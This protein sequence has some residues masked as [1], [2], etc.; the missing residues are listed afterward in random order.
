MFIKTLPV[1]V[2]ITSFVLT[3]STARAGDLNIEVSVLGDRPGNV[4]AALFD[5]AEG[6]PRGTPLRTAMVKSVQG[7]ANLQFAGLPKGD[8]AISAFLEENSNNKLDT[9]LFGIPTELYGF[10]RNARRRSGP[11]P[12]VEAAFRV[13]GSTVLMAFELK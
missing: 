4:M 2:F 8:Y 9:N 3:A 12:F 11:P 13:E 7:K 5:K 6:F 10:S 1:I